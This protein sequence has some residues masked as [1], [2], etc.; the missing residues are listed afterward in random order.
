[1][2]IDDNFDSRLD[3]QKELLPG[4]K[5]LW[6]GKPRTGMLL[7]PMDAIMIPFS[8]FWFGFALF[9][10][11]TVIISGAPFFFII[12]GIPFIAVGLYVTI[13]RFF[14]DRQMRAKTIYGITNNRVIIKSGVFKNTIN[15]F[16]IRTL[17]N[18]SL[19]EKSNGSGS[20]K[21][22]ADSF[23]FSGFAVAGW[24]VRGKRIPQIELIPN[25][26]SVYNL[27][28]QQQHT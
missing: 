12:W 14:Y 17:Q 7:R 15:T 3:L 21:L 13:G 25:V 8:I 11:S 28:L 23:P 16:N 10:E 27:I 5:L 18:I 24:P 26:R 2:L 22:A 6:T 20:I 4:E 9:W 1:M 19:D